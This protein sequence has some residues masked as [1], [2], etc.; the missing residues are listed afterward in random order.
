[1]EDEPDSL[2][3]KF[4]LEVAHGVDGA[5]GC[6][7]WVQLRDK[8]TPNK[9]LEFHFDKDERALADRDEW[10]HPVVA[11]ATYLTTGGAPLVI[12]ETTPDSASVSGGYAI[13]PVTGRHV[14]FAGNRLHGVPAELLQ[15]PAVT[16]L[17]VLVNVW[18]ERPLALEPLQL[19]RDGVPSK[20][21]KVS[22]PYISLDETKLVDP[23]FYDVHAGD[24]DLVTLKEH[25]P[26]D[27]A[28]IPLIA[29]AEADCVAHFRYGPGYYQPVP[30]AAR[31]D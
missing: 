28:Q 25:R 31:P 22:R 4:A 16:R 21:Q 17:S 11:T 8:T 27:T 24:A 20:R 23:K 6:E 14:R 26:G 9:G 13:A 7:V 29:L 12:F 3:G 18:R 2:L 19:P 5:A 1:M 30:S 15:G 10:R